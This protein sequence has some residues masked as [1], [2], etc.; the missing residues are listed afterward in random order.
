MISHV[1]SAREVYVMGPHTIGRMRSTDEILAKNYDDDSDWLRPESLEQGTACVVRDSSLGDRWVRAMVER[2]TVPGVAVVV[3]T[4]DHGWLLPPI[5][6]N[7]V[8]Q[9]K[10][11]RTI[12]DTYRG[13]AVSFNL[14]RH[15]SDV[16]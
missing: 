7:N 15:F 12:D 2:G 14:P 13:P 4:V 16:S 5:S 3:R 10:A 8:S 11:L 1:E 9:I 6:W